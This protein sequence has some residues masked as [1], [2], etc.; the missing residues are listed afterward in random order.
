MPLTADHPT[1]ARALRA[2]DRAE[3]LGVTRTEL[4]RRLGRLTP[5]GYGYLCDVLRGERLS[6]PVVE[7]VETVLD[8]I[9]VERP[10]A[11]NSAV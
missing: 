2:A 1:V 7:E 11:E 9:A 10:A 5:S 3:A 6:L 4:A 8:A